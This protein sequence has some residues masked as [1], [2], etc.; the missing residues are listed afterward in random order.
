M[1]T[2]TCVAKVYVDRHVYRVL[3]VVAGWFR[4]IGHRNCESVSQILQESALNMIS[5][6]RLPN[7]PGMYED[8]FLA[9]VVL[10]EKGYVQ[11]TE[12]DMII[13]FHSPRVLISQEPVCVA[14]ASLSSVRPE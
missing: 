9:A 11:R 14:L 10:G 12:R 5:I 3:K 7:L 2:V 6:S 8:D 4:D 1:C 13:S